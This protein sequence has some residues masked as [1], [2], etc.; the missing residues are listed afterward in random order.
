MLTGAYPMSVDA[1]GRVTLPAVFRKQLVDETSKTI[2]LV[3]FDGCVNG[4]T[5]EGF[6]AWVDGLFEYGDH[7]FD[8]RNR[9][10]VML[11]R[12]LMGSAVEVDIDSAGRVALGKLDAVKADTR[13]K[14][15][16]AGDVTVVGADDHF[17]VWNT[18]K[19]NEQQADFEM[20]LESLLYH[21]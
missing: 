8:P 15:G 2:L 17:E 11:K 7:H 19:W 16:L 3:P 9:K 6:K 13:E 14:Y 20:D 18:E 21:D 1:K 10:D 4:F 5:R 12:G